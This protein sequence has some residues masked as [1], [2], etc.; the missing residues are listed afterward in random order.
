MT[1]NRQTLSNLMHAH[2]KFTF[3]VTCNCHKSPLNVSDML[4]ERPASC[5]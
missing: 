4:M 3:A 1:P 5:Y 2:L